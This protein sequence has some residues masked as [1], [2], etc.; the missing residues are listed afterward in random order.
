MPYITAK[1]SFNEAGTG[2][3]SPS[4]GS[5]LLVQ[6]TGCTAQVFGSNMPENEA[7]WQLIGSA[8]GF[9]GTQMTSGFAYLRATTNGAG[10]VSI[11][12]AG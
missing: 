9:A 6:T 10:T 12:A 11:S 7:S 1:H 5:A 2:P 3:F 8:A 4:M